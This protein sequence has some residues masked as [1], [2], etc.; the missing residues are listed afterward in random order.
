MIELREICLQLKWWHAIFCVVAFVH[1]SNGKSTPV[2]AIP[3]HLHHEKLF[4]ASIKTVEHA[5]K[6]TYFPGHIISLV[7]DQ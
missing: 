4:T 3:L 1:K 5:S 7:Y 6:N 2:I